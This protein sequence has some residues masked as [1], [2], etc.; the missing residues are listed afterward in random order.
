MDAPPIV[1]TAWIERS[2]PKGSRGGLLARE[3]FAEYRPDIAAC[4]HLAAR[5]CRAGDGLVALPQIRRPHEPAGHAWNV[6]IR[7]VTHHRHQ[8][9]V[10]VIGALPAVVQPAVAV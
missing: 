10:G 2:C 6:D 4:A 1:L 3:Q 7:E 9:F 8:L 5:K